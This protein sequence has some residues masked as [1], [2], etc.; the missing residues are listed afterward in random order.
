MSMYDIIDISPLL[1]K[2]SLARVLFEDGF[3]LWHVAFSSM[4]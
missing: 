2:H 1:Q 3:L 4:E